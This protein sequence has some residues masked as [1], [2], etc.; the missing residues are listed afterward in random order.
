MGEKVL[1]AINI[2]KSFFSVKVLIDVTFNVYK[3]EAMALLG[4]NGAGKSTL[5][6]ILTGIYKKD[7]G[8]IV[9]NGEE[10][11]FKSPLEAYNSG[12]Y[13]LMQELNLISE[14]TVAENIFLGRQPVNNFKKINWKYMYDYTKHLLD[15]L[16]LDIKPNEL[17][18]NL[19]VANQK[20]VELARAIY[21]NANIIIMDEPTDALTDVERNVLF[22]IIR[23]LKNKGK[24]IVYITHRLE[25]I[26][27]ICDRVTVLR[28]GRLVL[29][30][31]IDQVNK[32]LLIN[33]MVGES[34]VS[35][36]YF[37][38]C[39]TKNNLFKVD[40]LS[41]DYL[42]DISFTINEGEALGVFGLIGAGRTYLAK[43]LFG[44]YPKYKGRIYLR[45]KKL[46]LKNCREAKNCGIIYVSEDRKNEGLV[47][48]LTV[49]ENITLSSLDKY[50]RLFKII[51]FKK[52][53]IS[54]LDYTKKLRIKVFSIDQKVVYL[55]GGNQQKVSIAKALDTSP[56]VL[57]LDEP[58][59][60]V[61]VKARR[62]IYSIVNELKKR[63]LAIIFISSDVD[64]IMGISDNV[65]VMNKG[66]KIDLLKRSD[67]NKNRLMQLAFNVK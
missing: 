67:I 26:F 49:S 40:N 57:I 59:R 18:K 47:V 36:N 24:S 43:T 66:R 12:I 17:V 30:E 34:L 46:L 11:E 3:G 23:D 35:D 2:N 41:N 31:K 14:L 60:G 56:T 16:S 25:E 55:S 52:L 6:K 4:E 29:E 33:K 48:D 61:D 53:R 64:E 10:L 51:D 39:S 13:I 44:I 37:V 7:N 5:V 54:V 32:N 58:T 8:S 27:E 62:E 65:L 15:D 1:S 63:G 20:M 45:G 21:F 9:Y 28:D 42:K 22:T 19:S 38:K 50:I